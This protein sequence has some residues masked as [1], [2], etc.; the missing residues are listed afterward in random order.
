MGTPPPPKPPQQA[1]YPG[2]TYLYLKRER[3]KWGARWVLVHGELQMCVPGN[4]LIVALR[5]EFALEP[6]S[7][8][9]PL[10]TSVEDISSLAMRAYVVFNVNLSTSLEPLSL[11]GSCS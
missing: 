10:V 8:E 1:H 9:Y 2:L 4:G 3:R 5:D 11:L 7:E 6:L